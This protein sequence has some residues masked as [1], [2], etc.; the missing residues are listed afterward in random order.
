MMWQGNQCTT[1]G[2]VMSAA[3]EVD[4]MLAAPRFWQHSMPDV[5]RPY[6]TVIFWMQTDSN[7]NTN[8]M[9]TNL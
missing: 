2:K 9:I 6:S 5:G 4:A 8:A 1:G 7:S 3:C